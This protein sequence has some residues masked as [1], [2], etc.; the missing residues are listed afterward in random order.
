MFFETTIM[1]RLL[2]WQWSRRQSLAPS[3][4]R[5]SHRRSLLK[6]VAVHWVL[7]QS[8]LNAMLTGRKKLGRK[9]CTS[10]RDDCKLENTVKQ[11]RFKHLGELHKEW[12]EAGVSGSRVTMLR[13]LREKGYQAT[14]ETETMSEGILP[15]L[16]RKKTWTVF[17]WSK[18]LFS[19]KSKFCISF[20]NQGLESGGKTG[21]AQYP[22]CLKSS[23]K[24]PQSVMIWGAMTSAGVRPLS[25]VCPHVTSLHF[26]KSK[27]NCSHLQEIWSTLC[28]HLLT[29][30]W[31]CWFPFPA[32]L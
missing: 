5:V 24:F 32:G 12:T 19:D 3:T 23:V 13:H 7:Y 16:R 18:V 21:E 26:I 22:S 9:R 14:S 2:T 29:S 10:N 20:G 17:Q 11:S 6:G 27:V 30:L 25:F 28:F 8:I 31:R 1:G 15:G 4:K